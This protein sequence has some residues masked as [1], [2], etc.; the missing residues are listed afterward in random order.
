MSNN[1]DDTAHHIAP[2]PLIYAMPLYAGLLLHRR[3]PIRPL[4]PVLARPLGLGLIA[5]GG[6]IISSAFRTMRRAGNHPTP[7]VPVKAIVSSGP[8]AYTRNP[9]YLAMTLI[10]SGVTLLVDA[11]WPALF[12]PVVLLAIRLGVIEH[13]ERYLERRFGEEY[14]SYKRSVRRWV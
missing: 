1:S 14:R 5:A 6:A 13:E 10:Y 2:P 3:R 12:L 4:P 9:M 11:L 8:F 7:R